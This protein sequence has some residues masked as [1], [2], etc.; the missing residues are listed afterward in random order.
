MLYTVEIAID[1]A[2]YSYIPS[3]VD[4]KIFLDII[5]RAAFES[6]AV[7]RYDT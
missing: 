2:Q 1:V 5:R 7:E 4:N 3:T 6:I